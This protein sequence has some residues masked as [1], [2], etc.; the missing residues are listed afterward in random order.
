VEGKLPV[1]FL[2]TLL[3]EHKHREAVGAPP[4]KR[5]RLAAL[6]HCCCWNTLI[7]EEAMQVGV[8][9]RNEFLDVGALGL[10]DL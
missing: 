1:G 8:H 5:G 4:L 7:I 10:R 3:A 2:A 9:P 6:A